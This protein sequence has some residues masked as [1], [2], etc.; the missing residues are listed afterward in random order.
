MLNTTFGVDLEAKYLQ[1]QQKTIG[2]N[3]RPTI[4][5]F[6]NMLGTFNVREF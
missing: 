3:Y 5:T 2:Y 4:D 6:R 1:L